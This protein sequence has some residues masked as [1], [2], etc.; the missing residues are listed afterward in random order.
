MGEK[1][2]SLPEVGRGSAKKLRTRKVVEQSCP[3][4]PPQTP[5]PPGF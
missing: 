1:E 4:F 2:R 5:R 3:P